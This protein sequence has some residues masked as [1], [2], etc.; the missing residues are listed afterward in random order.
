[1]V[2]M[3]DLLLTQQQ[4]QQARDRYTDAYAAMQIKMLEYRQATGQ[5]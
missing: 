2:T 4:Y 3:T 5:K 1:M